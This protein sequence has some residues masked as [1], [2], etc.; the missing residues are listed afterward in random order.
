MRKVELEKLCIVC[1]RSQ[2]ACKV[3]VGLRSGE[4]VSETHAVYLF[5]HLSLKGLSIFKTHDT[6]CLRFFL[7]I[8]STFIRL[9]I[10]LLPPSNIIRCVL[11]LQ[12]FGMND[13]SLFSVALLFLPNRLDIF[14]FFNLFLAVLDLRFYA[15]AFSSCGKRGPLFITVCGPLTI[16]ASLVAEHR[17][18]TRRLSSC[19]SRA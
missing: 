6:Y 15:R 14:F 2:S 3:K 11:S 13:H 7:F 12:V 1:P 8:F 19:G 16:A 10:L 17:L 18:Q 9:L 4:S 5:V